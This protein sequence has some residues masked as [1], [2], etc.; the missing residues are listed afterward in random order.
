MADE[1]ELR[2]YLKRAARDLH[3]TRQRLREIEER[4]TEP[5]AI[6]GMSCRYPG[7]A[8]S[9]EELWDLL[10]EGRDAVRDWPTDRGWDLNVLYDPEGKREGT[11]YVREGGF[12]E[13]A[14]FDAG[15]FGI[16]PR[17]ALSMDPQQRL[18]LECAWEVFERAEIDPA[19][20]RG[21]DTGVFAGIIAA[22]YGGPVCDDRDGNAAFMLTGRTASVASGRISY[23]FGF[24]GPAVTLDTACS[25]SLVA[26]HQAVQALR[27][28]ECSLA[29]AGGACV[30]PHAD[31][32]VGFAAQRG[33]SADG[34]CKSYSDSA[35]G[36]AWGEGVGLVLLER[37]SDAQAHG[38]RVLAVVRGSAVNQDGASNGLVAPNGPSQQRVIRAALASAGLSTGD[39]DVVEGHGTG[40]ALG[41]PIEAHALLMTYGRGRGNAEPLLLGSIKSNMGHAQAAAGVAGVIKMVM[42]MQHGLVPPTLHVDTPSSHVDWTA[43]QVELVTETQ[44]WPHT[45][46]PRRAAVSS[47]GISG[48]NAHIIVEQAPAQP[49]SEESNQQRERARLPLYAWPVS[50]KGAS[51]ALAAQA[52]RLAEFVAA[53]PDLDPADVAYSLA[54]TRAVFDHRAV[55]F[56]ADRD[57]LLSG[58]RSLATGTA[59][60][61]VV[62]GVT[63]R[64]AAT[65]LLFPGQGAQRPGMGRQLRERFPVFA[66][67]TDEICAH[68]D[69]HFDPPFREVFFAEPDTPAAALLDQTAYTQAALFT[70][71]V[72]LFRLLESLGVRPDFLLGHSIG[73]ISA[74]YVAGVWSLSDAC[75]LVAARGT[76]MQALPTGGAMVS[77]AASEAEVRARLNGHGDLVGVAAVNGP[78]ATVISGDDSAVTEIAARFASEGRKTKR[79]NVSHAFHSPLMEPMLAEFTRV[80]H[81]LEY[82]EPTITVV[83]NLTGAPAT[84][85]QLCDPQYWVAHVRSTVRYHDAARWLLDQGPVVH[86]E[87]GP[88]TTLTAM[89]HGCLPDPDTAAFTS[90]PLLRSGEDEV[91]GF[92]TA[93]G[94]AH[95]GGATI[96]W[97]H[98]HR[99]ADPRTVAL[100]TYA[101]QHQRYWLDPVYGLGARET[102]VRGVE[103]PLLGG[104][105]TLAD[106]GGVLLTSRL[107][108]HTH[109]WLADHTIG[110]SVLLPGTAFVEMALHIGDSI[111]SPVVEELI[112]QAPLVVPETDPVELQIIVGGPRETGGRAIA[113]YSRPTG[114]PADTAWTAHATGVLT[115]DAA[116]SAADA[117]FGA[118]PPPGAAALPIGA[119]YEGLAELGYDYGPLFRGLKSV[120]RQGSEVFAEVELPENARESATRFG[121]HPALLDAALHAIA[122]S[123]AV[124]VDE[125]MVKLPF[126]WENVSLFA[127][128][129]ASLRVRIAAT[130]ADAVTIT[131]ADPA[132][133]VVASV[134]TLRFAAISVDQL[135]LRG[136]GAATTADA[137]FEL[138]WAPATAPAVEL[139]DA[140]W[141]ALT[142]ETDIDDEQA[143]SLAGV[144][145]F[146]RDGHEVAVLTSPHADA[147]D[148]E[149]VRERVTAVMTQVQRLL[150]GGL[151]A[152]MPLA[153][154]TC[155]AVAVDGGEDVLDL[156][157]AA[158]WGLLRSA[159]NENPGR[160]ILIDVPDRNAYRDG[161]ATALSVVGE[162]QLAVRRGGVLVPRLARAGADSVGGAAELIGG[163]WWLETKG[164]GT[165][166]GENMVAG[167]LPSVALESGQVR[168]G[169]RAAGMNFRDV[170]IVLGMYPDPD[171]PIGGEGAG[172]VL[173]VGPDV[174]DFAPDDRVMGLFPGVGSA[175]VADSR[176]LVPIPAGWSFEDAAAVPIVFA[177]AYYSL[178]DLAGVRSGESILVHAATGGVG[179]AAVQL[180]RHLGLEVFATASPPKWNVLRG[181]GFD[182]DHIATSRSAEFESKFLTTTQ[183]RG[184]DVVLDSLAG[185]LVDAGLRLLPRGGRFVEMGLTDLRDPTAIA[186]QYAGVTYRAFVLMEAGPVRLGQILRELLALFDSGALRPLPVTRWDVRRAP[187]AFRY[188]SQARHIGKNVLT[189]PRGLDGDGTVL[190]TGGTGGLGAMLA[191]HLV[192]SHGARHLLLLSRRGPAAESAAELDSGLRAAGAETVRIVACDAADRSALTT[193]LADID[194]RHPLTAVVH[195][196]GVIDDALFFAQ[197]DKQVETVFRSKVDAAWNLHELTAHLDLTAFVMYSSISGVVGGPGQANY[198]AANSFLD[199]LAQYRRVRGLPALSL[200]WGMWGPAT[201][202]T[203]HLGEADRARIRGRG[204]VALSEAEGLALFDD[205]WA[206]GATMTVPAGLDTAAIRANT[207]ADEIPPAYRGLFRAGRRAADAGSGES[208]KFVSSLAGLDPAEQE[209]RILEVIRTH[210]AAILGHD[211][212]DVIGP[213]QPF[214]ELGFDSLGAVEFRNRLKAATGSKLPTTVIFDYPTPAALASYIRQ[215]IAPTDKPALRILAQVDS[216]TQAA[217]G[218]AW[219]AGDLTELTTKLTNL[220]NTLR[221]VVPDGVSE[222]LESADDQE[223]FEFIDQSSTLS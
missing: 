92:L 199:A 193:V 195:T 39:V 188:L 90:A 216:L 81:G 116:G 4:A 67:A 190:I 9:P 133:G 150:A 173:E 23:V 180:A 75:A 137:L 212:P 168:V 32:F 176:T 61:L 208:S 109:P 206:S 44:Q 177:T 5:V 118:W 185:D 104:E 40:T 43:G 147:V 178:I 203:E 28:G 134:E 53:H 70:I 170:L 29:L 95:T 52:G 148:A 207:D 34:R 79:L 107:S 141:A 142:A 14:G 114:A 59:A 186:N 115:A 158:V 223:L 65:A 62:T 36:T 60:P 48:T 99:A 85:A 167:E 128:G 191:R 96:D 219:E 76:L 19:R 2:S 97:A 94:T 163:D 98:A 152:R 218:A 84:G 153:V 155:G 129:A 211:S 196:A 161:V 136:E 3:Q 66:A 166:S 162:P 164:A 200:A 221:G 41:D 222:K 64:P 179:M 17:E 189:V 57:E 151:P 37:L 126:A 77:I 138:T 47:F 80:C 131:I 119:A 130:G 72:A 209:K 156:A 120:W 144:E 204:V 12:M 10:I 56:G 21:S 55:V 184:V 49:N 123:G 217:T 140:D 69:G 68:F 74:A 22:P 106:S 88:G 46:R 169:L 165:L 33:L 30:Y 51:S 1:E 24:E 157:G 91:F 110:G 139:P 45:D 11:T 101:F 192:V 42:A 175:V 31:V 83:S 135:A 121:I 183:G 182:D 18:L 20:L 174:T 112:L 50:G 89:L 149:S 160:I 103:H 78:A 210:G 105:L 205:S 154:V 7:G 181:M 54:R 117:D 171:A 197:T 127:V 73:E 82:H 16:S 201:G 108:L 6:V 145:R 146:V 25:S 125:G 71:E 111:D 198:A 132:A 202:M 35:D 124:G 187:E 86:L 100:P 58:L 113:F 215:E 213:D 63:A 159:Q 13:V 122:V 220:L 87:A 8:N 15:F 172:I 93:L 143:Q 38:H 26:I 214:M 27:T 102:G 194:A